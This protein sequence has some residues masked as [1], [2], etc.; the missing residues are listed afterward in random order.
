MQWRRSEPANTK[1]YRRTCLAIFHRWQ[2][3]DNLIPGATA[4][5]HPTGST[6][7]RVEVCGFLAFDSVLVEVP[8]VQP[9]NNHFDTVCENTSLKIEPVV[10]AT[11]QELHWF[12][13][14]DSLPF[15]TG[16][17]YEA[18]ISVSKFFYVQSKEDNCWS[19]EKAVV[20]IFAKECPLVI[21]N[22]F[23]PNGD[24][25]NDLFIFESAEGKE[26]Q[27]II[28]NR[29]GKEVASFKGNEGWDG[30]GLP[31]GVY[32]Y[33]VKEMNNSAVHKTHKGEMMIVR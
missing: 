24:G 30:A 12:E 11:V 25:I 7:Y 13:K 27:T 10:D 22:V 5:H 3:L 9:P 31:E 20:S 2:K 8:I 16:F 29:W 1:F 32:F 23:T 28:F 33:A 19:D 18:F 6:F 14:T 26:L 17:G 4:S 15:H 21:P